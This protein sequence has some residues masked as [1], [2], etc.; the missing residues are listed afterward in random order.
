M[1]NLEQMQSNLNYVTLSTFI[2]SLKLH[3][4]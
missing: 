3:K 1:N 2:K 4:F